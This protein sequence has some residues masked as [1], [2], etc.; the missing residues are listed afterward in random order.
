MTAAWSAA[1]FMPTDPLL[2][3]GGARRRLRKALGRPFHRD[4]RLLSWLTPSPGQSFV[5]AGA[6]DGDASEAMRLYHPETQILAF[7]PNPVRARMMAERFSCDLNVSV[8]GCGL[9]DGD[10]DAV[11]AAPVR[12]DQLADSEA[13]LD[14]RRVK[15]WDQVR[16]METRLFPLDALDLEV[17]VLKI[18]VN[19]LEH[20]V[21]QGAQE[22][23]KRCEPL[24]LCALDEAADAYLTGELG[25]MRA[26]FDGSRL[27]P[28]QA[29][30][31]HAFYAG[32]RCEA[33]MWR[34]GLVA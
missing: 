34:A 1:R 24:V 13:S 33:A 10:A 28:G 31:R 15:D 12:G 26:R 2:G 16:W 14:A 18:T 5:D 6:F 7:E 19:G 4:Y 25:W 27:I 9:G 21:L 32:P 29:G 30:R 11:L 8:Y 22:T 17:S 20:A 23:L 3:L